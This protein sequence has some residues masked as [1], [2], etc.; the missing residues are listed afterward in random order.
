M[1]ANK[2]LKLLPP[3]V[4]FAIER[5]GFY[6]VSSAYTPFGNYAYSGTKG[7]YVKYR[8]VGNVFGLIVRKSPSYGII[9]V[10]I[11]GKDYGT[12]DLYAG[13]S[14]A[15]YPIIIADNLGEG[16]HIAEIINT[17]EKNPAS[18]GIGVGI[19]GIIVEDCP[20]QLPMGVSFIAA[21][22]LSSQTRIYGYYGGSWVPLEVQSDT[23]PNLRVSIYSGD[24]ASSVR[25]LSLDGQSAYVYG[26]T[27]QACLFGFNGSTWDR[28]RCDDERNLL[29]AFKYTAGSFT[30]TTTDD[31]TDAHD[32]TAAHRYIH[33]TIIIK[34]TGDTNSM[35]YR[36]LVYAVD[37]G[38]AYEE[39]SGTLG[40]GD[41][42]KIN[43]NDWYNRIVIQVKS[44]TAGASTTYRIDIGG[45]KG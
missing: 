9:R 11:D 8:F 2:K 36:V 10:K 25:T 31:W 4:E 37:D 14:I 7:N 40:P 23:N 19:V 15:Q 33:K 38:I 28:L 42:A 13:K 34:N 16:E 5:S 12:I 39:T 20:G 6:N 30:G 3:M 17:G 35:D 41:V 18:D 45:I 1:V 29:I 21:V 44:T 32:W 24:N 27:T 43:L 26:T 22:S